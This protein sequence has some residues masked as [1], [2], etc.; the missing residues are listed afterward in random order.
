MPMKSPIVIALVAFSCSITT[1]ASPA[2]ALEPRAGGVGSGGH[3][4]DLTPALLGDSIEK[5][6]AQPAT[7]TKTKTK[8]KTTKT[9]KTKTKKTKSTTTTPDT[10]TETSTTTTDVASPTPEPHVISAP[11]CNSA[12]DVLVN[13]GCSDNCSCQADV[14]GTEYCASQPSFEDRSVTC[15]SD[16]DCPQGDFCQLY[17]V[18]DP[19]RCATGT[20]PGNRCTSSYSPVRLFRAA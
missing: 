12:G 6:V 11:R 10:T 16:A 3:Y 4:G 15:T 19:Y 5:R 17:D 18:G 1:L 7:K 13:G 2:Q 9:K 14:D 8:T 20:Q